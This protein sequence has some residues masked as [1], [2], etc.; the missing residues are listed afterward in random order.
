MPPE[1]QCEPSD[2]DW[3]DRFILPFVREPTLWPVLIVLIAHAVAFIG[4][5]LLFAVR[6]GGRG[7]AAALALLALLSLA[8]VRFEWRRDQRLAALSAVTA[9]TWLGSV[10]FAY[11][12]HRA[13]LL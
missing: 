4:P 5:A 10:A 7:W 6:D 2:R 12:S 3:V 8:V 9:V 11:V 1:P 13:H